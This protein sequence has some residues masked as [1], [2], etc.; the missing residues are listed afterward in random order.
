MESNSRDLVEHK[1][2]GTRFIQPI[3]TINVE[4]GYKK[5]LTG[6]PISRS[7]GYLIKLAIATSKE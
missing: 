4:A 1:I 7:I 6:N 2:K 3:L 5:S